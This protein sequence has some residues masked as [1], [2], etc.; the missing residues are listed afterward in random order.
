MSGHTPGPWRIDDMSL[1]ARK[2]VRIEPEICQIN[3]KQR[4]DKYYGLKQLDEETRANANLIAAAPELLEALKN[5]VNDFDKSVW[6]T[7]PM[8][9]AARAAIAKAERREPCQN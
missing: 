1:P 2:F 6:T 5:L 9:I 4:R 7:E 8:L 3:Q